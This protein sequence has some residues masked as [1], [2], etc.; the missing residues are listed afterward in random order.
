MMR[1]RWIWS[2]LSDQERGYWLGE[3][4]ARIVEWSGGQ[5]RS[6]GSFEW[7]ELGGFAKIE[8]ALVVVADGALR[9]IP[10]DGGPATIVELAEPPARD[11]VLLGLGGARL[12]WVSPGMLTLRIAD[13]ATGIA[14]DTWPLEP[15]V[16]HHGPRLGVDRGRRQLAWCHVARAVDLVDLDAG[17]FPRALGERPGVETVE[18]SGPVLPPEFAHGLW[19][20]E[21]RRELAV[22]AA[23]A[24]GL[25]LRIFALD[26]ETSE[27]FELG[28]EP[29]VILDVA[30]RL[31][32]LGF[33]DR[34]ELR[35]IEGG[36]QVIATRPAIA[37][38]LLGD[39]VQLG[40]SEGRAWFVDRG[41]PT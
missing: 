17:G 12:A 40:D 37:A 23:D 31:A 5:A 6:L 25:W 28:A 3:D 10:L 20:D 22:G 8:G 7:R 24:H 19:F 18:V 26:G 2:D 34:V 14:V 38:R 1:D 33:D 21:A 15:R 9:R 11:A 35:A 32:V 4:P 29:G 41:P 16:A 39:R 30:D 36:T 13:L 27:R